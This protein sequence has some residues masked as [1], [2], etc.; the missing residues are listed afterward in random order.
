MG[1]DRFSPVAQ[2]RAEAPVIPSP[3]FPTAMDLGYLLLAGLTAPWWVRK[4]RSGWAERFGRMESLGQPD[5]PRVLLHAVSVGEVASLR[6]VVPV[7]AEHAEVVIAAT[8]DTGIARARELYGDSHAVVRYPIDASWAV[9]RFLDAVRPDAV[10]LVE[11]EIWPQFLRACARRGTPVGVIS[12]RISERSFRGYMR[13]RALLRRSFARLSAAGAQ[14]DAVLERFRALG[15]PG[16]RCSVTGSIK[17][18]AVPLVEQDAEG[19]ARASALAGA[20]GIDRDRPVIV[21]G[22]TA[23][24]EEA[25]LHKACPAGVQLVCAPRKP[26]RFD[27]AAAALPGCTRRSAGEQRPGDR[28]LLDTI[29]ELGTAYR[30]ADVVVLGRSFGPLEGVKLHGSD[31]AEPAAL[32]RPVVIGER[33]GDFRVTVNALRDAGGLVVAGR[34]G[35]ATVLADLIADGEKR[36]RMGEASAACV[37]ANRGAAARNARL[38]LDLLPADGTRTE[39]T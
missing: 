20:M 15:T 4:P 6:P 26:E 31:P 22:S 25:L 16:D 1:G 34:D 12:G 18:D 3:K 35:L 27:D 24:G 32:G 13:A 30:L 36:T 17:W 28:F 29:G 38:L 23:P 39:R 37:A 5:R 19:D 10:G 9:A 8:T 2:R 33:F 21:A 11:L 14:D 7:L